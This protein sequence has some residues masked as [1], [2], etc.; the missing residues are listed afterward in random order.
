MRRWI[1]IFSICLLQGCVYVPPVW[2]GGDAIHGIEEIS[3]GVSTRQDVLDVLGEPTS[4]ADPGKL[5]YQGHSS[6][7]F[8]ICC[9]SLGG[10]GGAGKVGLIEED[11][12]YVTV[13]FDDSD[14]VERIFTNSNPWHDPERREITLQQAEEGSPEAQYEVGMNSYSLLRL[15]WLCRSA[16]GGLALA[17]Y[18]LGRHF[19]SMAEPDY[20]SAFVWHSLAAQDG[21]PAAQAA[22]ERL[23][24]ATTGS[25]TTETKHRVAS[26]QPDPD[27][28]HSLIEQER[29]SRSRT[30]AM[31]DGRT[32]S[33]S[34]YGE[35]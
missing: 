33:P 1:L 7:G 6:Y 14:Y 10:G 24:S 27:D 8:I 31:C 13:T 17:R 22:M 28:C 19:E 30:R 23:S 16:I 32:K 35:T 5:T 26:W 18:Q 21:L 34:R 9:L 15:E 4:D 12:W 29:R 11:P 3:E 25:E 2:D 20:S